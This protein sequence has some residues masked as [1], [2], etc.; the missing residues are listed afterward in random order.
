M[1]TLKYTGSKAYIRNDEIVVK[2]KKTYTIPEEW[3]YEF[4]QTV[5]PELE[6]KGVIFEDSDVC[7][8]KFLEILQNSS[9]S[10]G[11]LSTTANV[12]DLCIWNI[13]MT[14]GIEIAKAWRAFIKKRMKFISAECRAVNET[15]NIVFN[16]FA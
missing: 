16:E 1:A 7:S 15:N 13:R 4:G 10:Y 6:S 9:I 11:S 5:I 14:D 3:S 12:M 8:S 2:I